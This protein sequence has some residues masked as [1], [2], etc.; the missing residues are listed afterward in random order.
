VVCVNVH[1]VNEHGLMT[2]TL[3][4]DDDE[5]ETAEAEMQARAAALDA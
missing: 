3:Q 2:H 5:R 4:F 1:Q